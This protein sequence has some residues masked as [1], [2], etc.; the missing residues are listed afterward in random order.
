MIPALA[1]IERANLI[2]GVALT[3][4]AGLLWGTAGTLGAGAGALIACLDFY[5]LGRLGARAVAQVRQGGSPWGL[6]L[7]LIG[8]MTGL[9]TLVFIA[10]RVVRLSVI[11]FALGFS[12]FV[13]SIL[14]VGL[15]V[16]V[17]R[18]EEVDV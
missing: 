13:V 11:P 9:F 3:C 1:R 5:V 15:S 4:I 18:G 17:G 8:K 2:L 7:A 14:M 6:G 16:G 10:I 12:V